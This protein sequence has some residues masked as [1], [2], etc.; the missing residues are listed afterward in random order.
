LELLLKSELNQIMS[1]SIGSTSILFAVQPVISKEVVM[2]SARTHRAGFHKRR[3]RQAKKELDIQG[4]LMLR[5]AFLL[6]PDGEMFINDTSPLPRRPAR[7]GLFP[8]VRVPE[9]L[10][11][12]LT[13]CG[14]GLS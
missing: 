1:S 9:R 4:H 6:D 11:A 12:V 2:L 3:D 8:L 5:H 14:C 13:L 7:Q 10:R